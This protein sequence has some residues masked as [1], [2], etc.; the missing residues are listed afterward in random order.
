MHLEASFSFLGLPIQKLGMVVA[1]ASDVPDI[2]IRFRFPHPLLCCLL[3]Q[4]EWL[5][6]LY[7]QVMHLNRLQIE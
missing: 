2:V 6:T 1:T 3:S 5:T 4:K 7:Y